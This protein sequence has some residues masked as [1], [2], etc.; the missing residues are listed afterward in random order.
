MPPP[1]PLSIATSSIN[2][3][4]K[5]ESSYRTELANQQRRIEGL[6]TRTGTGTGDDA[7]E[8]GNRE[9]SLRQE[10]SLL[11]FFF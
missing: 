5:E 8:E 1:S 11:V 9:F 7:E 2:R 10:V 6:E 4:L 3:L